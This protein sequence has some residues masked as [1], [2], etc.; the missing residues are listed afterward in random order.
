MCKKL[1]NDKECCLD[2]L[3]TYTPFGKSHE[4][5][6][7]TDQEARDH[8]RRIDAYYDNPSPVMKILISKMQILEE[9]RNSKT[10]V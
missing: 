5:H 6:K 10:E 8:H 2:C 1:F 3:L 9:K 7:Y 4:I